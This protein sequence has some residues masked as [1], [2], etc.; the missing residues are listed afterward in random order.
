MSTRP[1]CYPVAVRRASRCVRGVRVLARSGAA[2]A[3]V[4]AL[5]RRPEIGR[6]PTLTPAHRTRRAIAAGSR[7]PLRPG[8][9]LALFLPGEPIPPDHRWGGMTRPGPPG[10]GGRQAPE[11]LE[12]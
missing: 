3:P 11:F 2:L 12:G 1:R 7:L 6:R 9:L 4:Q 8:A 10:S 5:R